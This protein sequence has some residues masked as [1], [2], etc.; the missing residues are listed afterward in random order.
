MQPQ[1]TIDSIINSLAQYGL[2]ILAAVVILVVGMWLAKKLKSI[3]T[4]ILTKRALEP[5]LIRFFASLLYGLLLVF[6]V[7]AAIGKLGIETTSFAAVL[8]AAGLAIGLALQGS[9]SNFAAGVLLILFKPFKVGDV[10]K[11]G[12]ELGGVVEVGLLSTELKTPDNVKIIMPNASIMA[13]SITN[14][15]AHETRRVDMTIGVSY[16][17][18][19]NQAKQIIEDI[20]ASDE[21]VLQEPAA[22]VAVANLGDSSIDFVVRPWVNAADFW[23]F[24][25]DFL[26]AVKERF[27]QQGVSIPYPQQDVHL[28][29]HNAS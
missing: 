15:S 21:R 5:T 11:A 3:F 28:F 13:G 9:L 1:T 10:I 12:G 27:D 16:G 25:F 23:A 17:D 2:K 20:L 8:A 4:A 14:L 18:D 26:Q 22:Q 7:I 29:Q 24:K 19:L 6:V